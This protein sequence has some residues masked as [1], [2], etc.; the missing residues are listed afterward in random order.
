MVNLKEHHRRSIRLNQ[1]NYSLPGAYFIT[2]CTHKRQYLFGHIE[3]QKMLLNKN[4]LIVKDELL[5][6]AVLRPYL[7][8]DEYVIMP[9]HLHA[10]IWIYD[11]LS[12]SLDEAGVNKFGK[13]RAKTL[14][15]IIGAFKAAATRRINEQ[16]GNDGPFVWQR[17]YYE[18]VIR[19]D[20]SM[21]EIREYIRYNPLNWD[22]DPENPA[23]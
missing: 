16:S 5:K 1:Y 10:I 22:T 12:E 23:V 9:N 4:G 2:I 6:T 13:P 7:S 15:S 11:P 19:R 17:N 20:E 8:I 18:H 21:K 14:G 3:D